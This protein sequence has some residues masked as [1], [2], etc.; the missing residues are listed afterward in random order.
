[1]PA[2]II[3]SLFS[4]RH[5]TEMLKKG[6]V[7][8][9]FYAVIICVTIFI[10]MYILVNKYIA[11]IPSFL[12]ELPAVEVKNGELLVNDGAPYKI[13]IPPR[14]TYGRTYYAQYDP[15]LD[16][17]P[18]E[19]DFTNNDIL[20]IFTKKA[21][22]LY[23]NGVIQEETFNFEKDFPRIDGPA[24]AQLYSSNQTAVKSMIQNIVSVT[25]FLLAGIMFVYW[26][27]IN[28]LLGLIINAFMQ[29]QVPKNAFVKL[30][31]FVQTPF[32]ILFALHL[33]AFTV[34]LLA[35]AQICLSGIYLQQILNNYPKKAQNAA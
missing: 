13:K 15:A 7:Y 29:R 8:T 17:P 9:F 30:A 3:K 21:A 2:D 11:Q 27:V 23:N 6:G 35:L 28:L 16:F 32:M 5:Y 25:A 34:P 14:L 26:F 31:V 20:V 10:C 33:F 22:Y 4:S 1:M 12:K 18:T 24:L 19:T